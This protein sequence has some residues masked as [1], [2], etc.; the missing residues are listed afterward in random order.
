[1]VLGGYL[2][3]TG[4]M[5]VTPAIYC[6]VH[7]KIYR[8]MTSYEMFLFMNMSDDFKENVVH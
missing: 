4:T 5:L 7:N 2:V 6:I 3:P 8:P 1:M